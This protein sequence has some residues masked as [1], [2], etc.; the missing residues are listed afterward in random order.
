VQSPAGQFPAEALELGAI[1]YVQS[2]HMNSEPTLD[3]LFFHVTDGINK[4]PSMRLNISI[5]V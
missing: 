1:R 2:F 5:E 4:S 3:A